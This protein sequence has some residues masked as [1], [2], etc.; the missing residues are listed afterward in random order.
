VTLDDVA[1]PEAPTPEALEP[2]EARPADRDDER[3]S[4]VFRAACAVVILPVYVAAVRNG[5]HHWVPTWDAATTTVRVNDVFSRNAPLI[6]MWSS[7]SGWSGRQINFIGAL[8]L[9]LLAIPV[10]LLG[11]TWGVLLGMAT[12]NSAALLTSAWLIRRRVGY[13]LGLVGCAFLASLV[14][15]VGSEVVVDIT[16]MQM[17]VLPYLLLLVA[18]WS[19]A[20]ADLAAIPVLAVVANY[21]LL[22]HLTFALAVPV[23][24]IW[25][26]ALLVW[27]LRRRRRD[28]RGSWPATRRRLTRNVGIAVGFTVLVWLPPLYQQLFGKGPGNL[29]A[30]LHASSATPPFVPK[31]MGALS[32]VI[33]TVAVPPLWFRPTFRIATFNA[34]GGG[35]SFVVAALATAVLL[36]LYGLGF[37]AARRRTDRTSAI[38]LATGLVAIAV[39]FGTAKKSTNPYGLRVNYLHSLWPMS[40]FVWMVLVLALIRTWPA[41]SPKVRPARGLAVV[42][43]TAVAVT[44]VFAILALPTRDLG[45]GTPAWTVPLARQLQRQLPAQVKGKGPILVEWSGA[46]GAWALWPTIMLDLQAQ[47]VPFKVATV[48]DEHQFGLDRAFHRSPP[49]ARYA[50]LISS[51]RVPPP[52]YHQIAAA[53]EGSP[54]QV[55]EFERLDKQVHDWAKNVHELKLDPATASQPAALMVPYQKMLNGLVASARASGTSLADSPVF[56]MNV[57][58]WF[59]EAHHKLVV[60]VPGIDPVLLHRWAKLSYDS[61]THDAYVY[62]APIDAA[63]ASLGPT[64]SSTTGPLVGNSSP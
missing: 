56:V 8:Q 4:W 1:V 38:G 11:T 14:W 60:Q 17:G 61:T 5:L 44:A 19:V 59:D 24:T 20:D 7:A 29:G 27:N 53:H 25:S 3:F 6:G 35:T 2:S 34:D 49:N 58:N 18:A 9:Y 15:A 55:A 13:R 51:N 12:L 42:G 37:W 45:A 32:A 54:A 31:T 10:K 22:D 30:L 23:L 48:S 33:A 16:P 43:A 28:D 63:L 21:L 40:V 50:L 62:L 36:L 39:G 64:S 26:L 47:G 57:S 46:T 41:W 52:G